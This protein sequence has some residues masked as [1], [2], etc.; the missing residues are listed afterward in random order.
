[1]RIT[2]NQSIAGYPALQ[3]REFIRKY[4]FT[5][6]SAQAAEAALMLSTEAASNLLSKLADLGYIGKSRE[7]DGNQLF[8]ST[9]SGQALPTL[10]SRSW[11]SRSARRRLSGGLLTRATMATA[12]R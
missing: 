12:A 6:F 9:I 11:R 2:T 3:V 10:C 4:R 5:N 1:M 7:R 8:Q